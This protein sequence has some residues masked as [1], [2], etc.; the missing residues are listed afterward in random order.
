MLQIKA[1]QRVKK[2][3]EKNANM[4][5]SLENFTMEIAGVKQ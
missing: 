5:L 3:L 2:A 1:V 4:R